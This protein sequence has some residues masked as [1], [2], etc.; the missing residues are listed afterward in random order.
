MTKFIA[1]SSCD[2]TELNGVD[3][4][5]V[6]LTISTDKVTFTDDSD[7]D[8]HEMLNVLEKHKGRSYTACPG[9]EGWINAFE[10]ADEIFVVTITSGMSGTYN[11]AMAAVKIYLEEHPEVKIKVIDSK[12]TGPEMRLILEKLAE[13]Y[14]NGMD[15]DSICV[16][17]DKYMKKTR[18]FCSLFSLHNLAQNGR[19]SKVVASAA[20]V[21]GICVIGTASEQGTLDSIAKCRGEKKLVARLKELMAAAGYN[22]GRLRICHVENEGL[23]RNISDI[24]KKSYPN[25][26][27]LYYKAGGLCSYYAER[28]GIILALETE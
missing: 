25:A 21:L 26:D 6:P 12:S 28:G 9:V 5:S 22:G 1:D 4:Q 20:G 27:V 3:F 23:A 14:K 7:M 24:V 16:A 2:I 10:G 15:F 11:S 13:Y 8:I 17:I 18:L 19:V